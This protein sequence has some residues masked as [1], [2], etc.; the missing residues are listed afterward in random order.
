MAVL[1]NLCNVLVITLAVIL[2]SCE[3]Q[4]SKKLSYTTED[5]TQVIINIEY[6]PKSKIIGDK[7]FGSYYYIVRFRPSERAE[8]RKIVWGTEGWLKNYRD[9]VLI[10]FYD[11][12]GYRLAPKLRPGL[13]YRD[14]KYSTYVAD[15]NQI[16]SSYEWIG[17]FD[18]NY[19]TLEIFR[20]IH[21]IKVTYLSPYK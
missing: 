4:T 2:V 9:R 6:K 7:K 12:K 11:E 18:E 8:A 19:M 10:A 5:G 20:E 15:E 21:A 3:Q 1:N 13:S 17:G 14:E 16:G